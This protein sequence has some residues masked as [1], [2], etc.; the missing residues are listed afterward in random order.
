MAT[1][2][3]PFTAPTKVCSR[4]GAMAQTTSKKCPNCGKS[5]KRRTFLK[6]MLALT[7]VGLVAIVGCTALIAGTANEI[8]KELDAQQAEHAIS[9]VQFDGLELGATQESVIADLGKQP[10]DRQDFESTGVLD[11]EPQNSSCIYYNVAGGTFGDTF[12]L[13]FTDGKLDSKNAY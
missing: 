13:C 6:V 7:I 10:E 9:R 5:Y 2:T 11:D 3:A 1:Q 12:Q 8:G 4:C